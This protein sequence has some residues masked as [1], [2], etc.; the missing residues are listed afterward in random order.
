[1]F[2]RVFPRRQIEFCRRFGTLSQAHI[3]RLDVETL[4]MDLTEGS[5]A[6][7]KLNLTRGKYPTEHTQ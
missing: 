3:Q 5:E 2:F 1:M 6:S 7:A 4:K